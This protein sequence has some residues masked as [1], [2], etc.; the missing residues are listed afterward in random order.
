[1]PKTEPVRMCVACR[2]RR[3]KRELLR[4]VERDGRLFFDPLNR[5]PGRGMN[6]CPE[7]DCFRKALKKPLL[8]RA[9]RCTL[10]GVPS[11]DELREQVLGSLKELI[12]QHLRL[13]Y[14]FRG[15]VLGREAVLKERHVPLLIVA[16]DLSENS[17]EELKEAGLEGVPLFSK[18]FWGE[19]FGR[20][21]VGIIG[22]TDRGLARKLSGLLDKYVALYR[23]WE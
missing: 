6:L 8:E 16:E 7:R 20:R 13:G 21:P 17:L 1:M 18:A 10:K 12:A 5:A 11:E 9:L 15:V 19:V 2:R 14:R 23:R 4:F 22:V 3:P